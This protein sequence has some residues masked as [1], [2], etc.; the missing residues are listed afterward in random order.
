MSLSSIRP[1]L[2]P[3][4]PPPAPPLQFNHQSIEATVLSYAPHAGMDTFMLERSRGK[5]SMDEEIHVPLNE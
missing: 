5:S 1:T 3:P 4:R 2:G